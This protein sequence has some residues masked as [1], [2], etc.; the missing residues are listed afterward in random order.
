MK[1]NA[2]SESVLRE[3]RYFA[4]MQN[5]GRRWLVLG[6]PSLNG[7]VK[8]RIRL[9]APEVTSEC[10]IKLDM[11]GLVEV[12]IEDRFYYSCDIVLAG[13]EAFVPSSRR[14]DSGGTRERNPNTP[15]NEV[16][17]DLSSDKSSEAIFHEGAERR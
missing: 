11:P 9:Y 15:E 1:S 16:S 4:E 10:S 3:C 13:N 5:V 7:M 12:I 6:A 2:L 17:F 8:F 14:V